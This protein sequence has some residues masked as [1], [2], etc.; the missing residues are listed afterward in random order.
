MGLDPRVQN[1]M[2]GDVQAIRDG[3][4]DDSVPVRTLAVLYAAKHGLRDGETVRLLRALKQDETF[5]FCH[6]GPRIANFAAAALHCLGVERYAG[7][8]PC[9][10][11]LIERDFDVL[12]CE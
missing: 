12:P 9:V 2:D 4:A 3:L 11:W 1:M 6:E 7:D 5:C 10:L 8:D